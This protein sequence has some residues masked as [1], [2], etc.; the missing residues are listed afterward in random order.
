MIVNGLLG[1]KGGK[2]KPG[3][4]LLEA[5]A[6]AL[7]R[8]LPPSPALS[9][10]RSPSLAP[11]GNATQERAKQQR[12][13]IIHEL[14]VQELSW[15]DLL[16]KW[17]H[18][19][20]E[21]FSAAVNKV[22]GFDDDLHKFAL[23]KMYWKELD[24]FEYHYAHEEDRQKAINNAIKQY[25]RMRL[26]MS[27]PL[28]QKL[29]PKSERGKGVCLSKLQANIVKG[30]TAPALKPKPDTASV[31]GGDSERDDSAS[32]TT[33]KS[34]GGEPMSRSSS[35]A[36]TGKKKLSASEAQAKRLLSTS[37]KPAAATVAKASP[38]ISP[39]KEGPK[40]AT[41]KVG[42]VLSKEF[43]SD[44]SSDD[45]EVPLSSSIAKSKPAAAPASKPAERAVEKPKAAKPR[46]APAL[47][48]KPAPAAKSLPREKEMDTIRAQ[49]IAKPIK[50]PAKRPRDAE[51]D[52]SS[53]SGTPLSKRVKPAV[54]APPAPV[55]PV[56]SRTASDASQNGRGVALPKAKN[57]SSIKSSPLAS[58]PPT[59][60]SDLERDRPLLGAARE[61]ERDRGREQDR[62]REN[63]R[64]REH[65]RGRE[66]DRAREHD[67]DTTVSSTS[68]TRDSS[69]FG[70]VASAASKKRAATDLMNGNKA[71]RSRPSQDTMDKA[72]KFRHFYAR[73]EQLHYEIA[74]VENPDPS[75]VTDLLDMRDRLSRMKEEIYASIEV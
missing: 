53:S 24:V 33:K 23:S 68:S 47:K 16:A 56:K 73:Y 41:S 11:S 13:P 28:W 66:R 26:G 1:A 45:D 72:T 22:A 43:V 17:D 59:N 10:T 63:D 15:P 12:F 27:D 50:P 52:D 69:D 18:G 51:D 5:Q 74:G 38:K 3:K 36:S 32:S 57:A 65:D 7:P 71:K 40:P 39:V 62:V 42:R 34:K 8:S 6:A 60:A 70:I 49:V 55:A 35:Q 75:K 29:L 64:V 37:K 61:R 44:S 46:E 48:P 20:R 21:E 67:R 9:G 54:K 19:T 25:D 2:G 31:S 4:R 58:S 14:A 30:P